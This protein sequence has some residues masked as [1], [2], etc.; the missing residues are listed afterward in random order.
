MTC[1]KRQFAFYALLVVL[2]LQA[3]PALAQMRAYTTIRKVTWQQLSNALRITVSADGVLQA[4]VS[5]DNIDEFID[6]SGPDPKPKPTQQLTIDI[7]NAK[8]AIPTFVDISTYPVSHLE[9]LPLPGSTQGIGCR[10][11]L[12]FYKNTGVRGLFGRFNNWLT[13]Y[14]NI[15]YVPLKV[16][17]K[18]SKDQRSL[19][20]TVYSDRQINPNAAKEAAQALKQRLAHAESFLSLTPHDGKVD[21]S[22]LNVPLSRVVE[23]FNSFHLGLHLLLPEDLNPY[24]TLVAKDKAPLDLLKALADSCGLVLWRSGG[25]Y[26]FSKAT[27][28]SASAY[29]G[30]ESRW[31]KL[32][33]LYTDD[34]RG[35]MP[36]FLLKDLKPAKDQNAFLITASPTL[37]AKIAHDLRQLDKPIRQIGLS[38]LIVQFHHDD[39]FMRSLTLR[40]QR[41]KDFLG[42]AT[43][44]GAVNAAL[45]GVAPVLNPFG[46][47]GSYW[48]TLVHAIK[49]KETVKLRA[50]PYL[51]TTCGKQAT[52][53][54]G[55]RRYVEH[56]NPDTG[57][58]EVI[59]VSLGVNLEFTPLVGSSGEI[60]LEVHAS[61]S[62][63]LSQNAVTG[64]P[65]LRTTDFKGTIRTRSGETIY[66]GGLT[67]QR[68]Q[69]IA[70][71]I[72]VLSDLP[73]IGNLFTSKHKLKVNSDL[74]LFVT[75]FL[76]PDAQG[77]PADQLGDLS[78][79]NLLLKAVKNGD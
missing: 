43:A 77:F 55:Q 9:V 14:W 53:F 31:V 10:L 16:E 13:H 48:D 34:A 23:Q 29:K 50:S 63:L 59:P 62:S 71:R 21:A 3:V 2:V 1:W 64:Q 45:P 68:S 28:S 17:A 37:Q 6:L 4:D 22:F 72:P 78:K 57:Q 32:Q 65:T 47:L 58:T 20:F 67:L 19:L 61:E 36:E 73:L 69:V 54:V 7:Y 30:A 56:V 70:S 25:Q 66:V 42:L 74:G 52:L 38:V 39:E 33:H 35:L 11:R 60:T 12:Y 41:G 24:V 27:P 8:T 26:V 5:W 51:V 40:L 18:I 76:L 44:T 46:P 75:P 15:H 49:T 79:A